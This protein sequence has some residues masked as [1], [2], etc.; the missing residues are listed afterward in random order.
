MVHAA[1]RRAIGQLITEPDHIA[2]TRV[3]HLAARQAPRPAHDLGALSA[4]PEPGRV[5]PA[6]NAELYGP[7]QHAAREHNA[8]RSRRRLRP[9]ACA[10]GHVGKTT[11]DPLHAADGDLLRDELDKVCCPVV[12]IG[13]S[14]HA[15]GRANSL[16]QITGPN[17]WPKSPAQITGPNHRPGSA[18]IPRG[19]A[20]AGRQR[21]S[22]RCSP[23]R[24]PRPGGRTGSGPAPR[25]QRPCRPRSS[26]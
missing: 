16:A 1:G 26:R 10:P 14:D 6:V 18:A 8:R 5:L 23:V 7:R 17:H 3:Q 2:A 25:G 15:H 22:C 19:H 4:D 24:S 11:R 13:K 9:R 20:P 12:P 21:M